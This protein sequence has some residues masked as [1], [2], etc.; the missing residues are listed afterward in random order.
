[1][2]SLSAAAILPMIWTEYCKSTQSSSTLSIYLTITM[3][4]DAARARSFALRSG[5]EIASGLMGAVAALKFMLVV[6]LEVRKR[7]TPEL[8]SRNLAGELTS[9]FWNR[10]IIAWINGLM[11]VGYRKCLR[12]SDLQNLDE[13]FSAR[14]LDA[15]FTR[16]W[17]KAPKGEKALF[18]TFARL[19]G[20]EIMLA[21]VPQAGYVACTFSNVYLMRAILQYLDSPD[22]AEAFT[23]GGLVAAT[24]L[25]Y[26]SLMVRTCSVHD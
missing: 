7:L 5:L 16:V 2:F 19:F 12:M 26:F 23:P 15:Q 24:V 14:Y 4:L 6:L 10:S 20:A 17:S 18:K 1:M 3:L 8:E 13:T 22:L 9:G 25:S 11:L 21:C